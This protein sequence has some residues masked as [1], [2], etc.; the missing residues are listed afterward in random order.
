[1][2]YVLLCDLLWRM[3]N[4]CLRIM[5][6]LLYWVEHFTFVRSI[7]SNLWS[8]PFTY[9]FLSRWCIH[10]LKWGIEVPLVLS[11]SLFRSDSI[12]LRIF[13]ISDVECIYIYNCCIILMNWPSYHHIMTVFVSCNHF[14][15]KTYFVWY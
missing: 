14:W 11:V 7:C 10:Y 6:I 5:C 1:M 12:C 9:W 15:P 2:F 13:K 4:L 3:L 8:S